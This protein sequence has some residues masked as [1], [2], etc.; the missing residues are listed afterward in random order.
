MVKN[1]LAAESRK[2]VTSG[3]E[4][5]RGFLFKTLFSA[6]QA[7]L[8]A[9]IGV[10]KICIFTLI[11]AL[12]IVSAYAQ[13][14][15]EP[16]GIVTAVKGQVTVVSGGV[17]EQV[18]QGAR[19]FLGDRFQTGENSGAKILFNDDTLISLGANTKFEITEFVYNPTRRKS[20]SNI[21]T[22]KIKA[23][24]QK[25]EGESDVQFITPKG[26]AGVKGTI[27]FID[28]DRGIFFALEREVFVR[29][30]VPGSR[31]IRLGPGEFT[32]IGPKGNPS[33]AGPIPGGLKNELEK[34]TQVNEETPSRDSLYKKD[35]P[36]KKPPH[37]GILSEL[38]IFA[39]LKQPVDLTPGV[40]QN[41]K[42]PVNVIVVPHSS[43]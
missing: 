30:I 9:K 39:P 26:V 2:S 41:D 7:A 21:L 6:P 24:I 34:G 11:S 35:Y 18:N 38:G 12:W 28:A 23:I 36:G 40:N 43:R 4:G 5:F 3:A 42:A 8:V 20:V 15:P 1:K 13:Q 10:L 14:Q 32:T 17:S 37:T 22:G 19:V 16:I 29:G 31:E 25:F 33:N 27:L